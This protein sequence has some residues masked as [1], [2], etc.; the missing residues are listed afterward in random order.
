MSN[1]S[2]HQDRTL[3]SA[4]LHKPGRLLQVQ[5][6]AADALDDDAVRACYEAAIRFHRESSLAGA[7]RFATKEIIERTVGESMLAHAKAI[8]N[9]KAKLRE[10]RAS[11]AAVRSTLDECV[12]WPGLNDDE[13]LAIVD[14]IQERY[15][16]RR[17][18]DGLGRIIDD[19]RHNRS[20]GIHERIAALAREVDPAVS[21][22]PSG[23]LSEDVAGVLTDYAAAKTSGS[24][25]IATP[26]PR[27]NK[28][29]GGGKAGR[30]WL[31]AA[32]T[33]EG[34][35]QLAKE[36]VYH[37]AVEQG[38]GAVVFTKEQTKNDVRLMLAVRHSHKF[39]DGGLQFNAV[40]RGQLSPKEEKALADS[41]ADLSTNRAFGPIKYF[42]VPG[43][44]NMRE[45]RSLLETQRLRQPVSVV[46]LDHTMLFEPSNAQNSDVAN[47]AQT[48][49][50]CKEIA[51][52]FDGGRGVWFVACHQ[53]KREGKE[54]ADK[55]GFYVSSD[56]AG[57]AEAERSSDV[58]L[59]AW[60][61]EKLRDMAELR[62]G[63][64]KDR[65]GPGEPRGWEVAESFASSAL[66]PIAET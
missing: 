39:I 65:W 30:L 53:I 14:A 23:T 27:L 11:L 19:L 50:D 3:L 62:L 4:L 64:S 8:K 36:L 42:Q 55:R 26:F 61:D 7:V 58:I 28:I 25:R 40:E 9:D 59:W 63:V 51:M 46:M 20:K 5:R 48:I 38:L 29:T 54:Q 45:V 32:Y 33:G 56:L 6:L 22:V 41:V 66:H 15:R 24:G 49:V 57:T 21:L 13:F 37:A 10:L 52:D 1:D 35:T 47:L 44:T 2:S 18:R 17:L 34:K 43:G 16:D 12:A 31:V 60:R